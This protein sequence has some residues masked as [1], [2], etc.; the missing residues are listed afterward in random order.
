MLNEFVAE[1]R[2]TQ[3]DPDLLV[4]A[5]WLEEKGGALDGVLKALV[6]K[7]LMSM[8]GAKAKIEISLRNDYRGRIGRFT[9]HDTII[10]SFDPEGIVAEATGMNSA[11][12]FPI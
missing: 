1:I 2:K 10:R 3:T 6:A 12:E 4:F 8:L 5:D 7:R 9:F 11:G